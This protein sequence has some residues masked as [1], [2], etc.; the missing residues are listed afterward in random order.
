M[1]YTMNAKA[2]MQIR[3]T[4]SM[5]SQTLVLPQGDLDSQE[6]VIQLKRV[7]AMKI[8]TIVWTMRSLLVSSTM[9][10]TL[11]S[12]FRS[13]TVP[14]APNSIVTCSIHRWISSNVRTE[15]PKTLV[16][17]KN[18][19]PWNTFGMADA[20]KRWLYLFLM[21]YGILVLFSG[22]RLWTCWCGYLF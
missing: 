16:F 3:Y 13:K 7:L 18:M 10:D 21:V 15:F 5:A 19:R 1:E 4:N 22:V 11:L 17:M 2:L 8:A 12:V 20:G 6:L 9:C 14:F